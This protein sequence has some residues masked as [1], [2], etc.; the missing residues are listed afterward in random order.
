MAEIIK[1]SVFGEIPKRL[2]KEVDLEKTY[3]LS[4]DIFQ[5]IRNSVS[6]E[7]VNRMDDRL[8]TEI[9][10]LELKLLQ[11][12]EKD[13]KDAQRILNS[14]RLCLYESVV[15][16]KLMPLKHFESCGAKVDGYGILIVILA[17]KD[18]YERWGFA[19]KE[20]FAD[21]VFRSRDRLMDK[22]REYRE[23]AIAIAQ[24]GIGYGGMW[25]GFIGLTLS[26]SF[27]FLSRFLNHKVDNIKTS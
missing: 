19:S 22:E 18:S 4:Q 12:L 27:F 5:K 2:V 7:E 20:K 26:I 3:K 14:F 6:N 23:Y 24:V 21:A 15:K 13:I 16:R 10:A 1:S 17:N 25:L 8:R 9:G 11:G